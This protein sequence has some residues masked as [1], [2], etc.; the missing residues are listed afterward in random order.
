MRFPH[1]SAE[2]SSADQMDRSIQV[3]E[4][5]ARLIALS[6]AALEQLRY[7]RQVLFAERPAICLHAERCKV[8]V[9]RAVLDLLRGSLGFDAVV[10]IAC[11]ILLRIA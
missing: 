6:E 1:Q 11:G 8:I 5:S 9:D 4:R 2:N 7:A 10:L 3:S